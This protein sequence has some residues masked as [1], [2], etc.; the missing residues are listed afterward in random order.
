[1]PDSYHD[2]QEIGEEENLNEWMVTY[3]DLVTLLFAFFVLLFAMSAV[4]TQRFS[5]SF[6]AVRQALGREEGGAKLARVGQDDGALLDGVMLQKQ[7]LAE[8][9]QVFAET[10]TFL[11]RNGVE[12][13]IGAVFDEGVITL[14]VPA[15]VLYAPGSA[16]LTEQGRQ[17]VLLLKNFFRQRGDQ[18]INIKGYTDD[19]TPAGGRF[20]DN[21]ELSS[22]RAVGVLRVLL[23]AGVE[24][25]RLTA[26]GLADLEPVVP[27]T[28][29]ENRARNRRVEFE[30]HRRVGK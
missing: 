23:E 17:T 7:L 24:P 9:R 21:W 30:L 19:V 1:M 2:D 18:Q 8:Q 4:D 27:N 12:G 29:D 5:D 13:V 16:T 20:Q 15:E 26:T 25:N 22:L 3:S 11:N 6:T 28:S 10:R 14:R